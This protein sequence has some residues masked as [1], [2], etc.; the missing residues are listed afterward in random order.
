MNSN[1]P[2]VSDGDWN[3]FDTAVAE[4]ARLQRELKGSEGALGE[5]KAAVELLEG[6]VAQLESDAERASQ[7]AAQ[8]Q[9]QVRSQVACARVCQ[10]VMF[11]FTDLWT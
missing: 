10:L 1:S 4:R 9:N 6:R 11:H 5:A 8:A 3:Q 2:Q 7:R